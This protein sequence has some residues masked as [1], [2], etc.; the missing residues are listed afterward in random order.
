M[1]LHRNDTRSDEVELDHLF[2]S[3]L[4]PNKDRQPLRKQYV[5]TGALPTKKLE[6]TGSSAGAVAP[7]GRPFSV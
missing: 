3:V 7:Q 1:I 5:F 6:E 4:F 2:R